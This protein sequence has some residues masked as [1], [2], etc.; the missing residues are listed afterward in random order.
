MTRDSMLKSSFALTAL[1]AA[2]LGI[3]SLGATP[4]KAQG[5]SYSSTVGEVVVH[6]HTLGRDPAT[7]APIDTVTASR[8]VNIG[9]LDLDSPWGQRVAYHRIQRAAT[10]ACD[11]LDAHFVTLDSGSPDCYRQAVS[12]GLDQVEDVVGHPIYRGYAG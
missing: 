11:Y 6:P 9:D 12:D 4:A 5:Y 8:Y 2:A 3:S 10:D 7:G 1:A